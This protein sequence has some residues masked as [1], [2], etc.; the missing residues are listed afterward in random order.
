[1]T[2]YVGCIGTLCAGHLLVPFVSFVVGAV[3]IQAVFG[4]CRAVSGVVAQS[5]IMAIVPK[6]FMGRTQSAMAIVT[7]VLQLIMSFALG[8]VAQRISLLAGFSLLGLMYAGAGIFATRARQ[9][10]TESS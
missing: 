6:H 7:T 1:M 4:F 10:L 2:F 8:W 9:L 3:T 5:S